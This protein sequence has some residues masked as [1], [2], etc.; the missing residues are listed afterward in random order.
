MHRN[1]SIFGTRKC[2]Y[3]TSYSYHHNGLCFDGILNDV[4]DVYGAQYAAVNCIALYRL[5]MESKNRQEENLDCK[6]IFIL[7]I[8]IFIVRNS[9]FRFLIF[10]D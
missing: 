4:K 5:V 1:L 7:F 8:N 2:T 6:F 9:H 10:A 3:V